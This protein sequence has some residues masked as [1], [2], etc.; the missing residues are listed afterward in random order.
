MLDQSKDSFENF[1]NIIYDPI[2]ILNKKCPYGT[3]LR[4][5]LPNQFTNQFEK[6]LI[7]EGELERRLKNV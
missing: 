7:I 4:R 2:T 1:L 3:V 6:Y 5:L